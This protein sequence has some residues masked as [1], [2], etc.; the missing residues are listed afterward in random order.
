MVGG[1]RRCSQLIIYTGQFETPYCTQIKLNVHSGL[2]SFF[3]CFFFNLR[4]FKRQKSQERRGEEKWRQN[5]QV[6]Q[7]MCKTTKGGLKNSSRLKELCSR[8]RFRTKNKGW[9]LIEL[10]LRT[11][12]TYRTTWWCR[13]NVKCRTKMQFEKQLPQCRSSMNRKWTKLQI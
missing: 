11:C 1:L 9:Q 6:G 5:F 2:S 13:L 12:M 4:A 3:F 8:I 10:Y 7:S